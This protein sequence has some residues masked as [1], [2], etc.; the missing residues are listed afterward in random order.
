LSF[1]A[2]DPAQRRAE[3]GAAVLFLATA[4]AS[5]TGEILLAPL[6]NAPDPL[7]AVADH[8]TTLMLGTL[9][10]SVNNIGIVFIAVFLYPFLRPRNAFVATAF[11]ATRIVEGTVMMAGILAA[12][13]LIPLAADYRA[14]GSGSSL[15]VL[16]QLVKEAKVLGISKLSLPLLGLGGGILTWFLY[17]ARLLPAAIALTGFAGYVLVIGGGLAGWFGLLEASPF[18]ASSLLAIPVA[19]FE[20]LLLP[21]WLLFRGFRTG[22]GGAS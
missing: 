8:P 10:W 12:L 20:I 1:S 22:N 13:L 11:L 2:Q 19:A 18:A 21:F 14:S 5:I 6:L 7:A 15:A 3:I 17:R 9:L 16:A 4:A